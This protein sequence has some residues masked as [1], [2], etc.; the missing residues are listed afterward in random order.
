MTDNVYWHSSN[1][2]RNARQK[3]TSIKALFFGSLA[4]RAME[5]LH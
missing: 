2:D 5:N 3:K 1:I 4:Y